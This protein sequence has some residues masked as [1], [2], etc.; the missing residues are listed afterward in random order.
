MSKYGYSSTGNEEEEKRRLE[1]EEG[2]VGR[3]RGVF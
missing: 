3:D 2:L 1:G